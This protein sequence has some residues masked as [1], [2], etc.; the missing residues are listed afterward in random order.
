MMADSSPKHLPILFFSAQQ[1]K[2]CVASSPRNTTVC[3]A[4]PTR[5]QSPPAT[6]ETQTVEEVPEW[7]IIQETQYSL[8]FLRWTHVTLKMRR[9]AGS[10]ACDAIHF[11]SDPIGVQ[12][13]IRPWVRHAITSCWSTA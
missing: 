10:F 5:R 4:T 3:L 11:G 6:P 1:E 9:D 12:A 2:L 8:P 13:P 7:L